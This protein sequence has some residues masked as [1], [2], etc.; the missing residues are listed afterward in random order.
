MARF[1]ID[2]PV[3]AWVIALFIMLGGAFAIRALPVAQYPDIAPPVVSIYAT[4]PGA[5]AQVV[6]ESVTALIEREMN[7][8]PGLLYTSATSSAGMASL[9]LTFR[10][11]VNA[12]LAAVEVQNRLKTVE[13]RLPEPVRR[14]G[15]QVEKAADNIQ[16]VVSLTSDDG[17]MTGV[18]LGEYASAN[19][20]QAL[21]R[22][23]GVG[24][25]QFWGAEYAMRIWPDPVKLAGHGLTASDIAAAVRA[26]N[27]RVTVGD[28]GRS[29]VPDSAPIAATVF[30]D[31]PLKTPAD[32]GAIALRSQADGAA[33]YLRDVAR[34]EFGGSD[35]NYPSY[36]NG[37]VAVGMGIK[38]AP[39]SNAVATEKR[40]RAA[41]DEL[42][43][44]FPPGVKYQIP[45]ETSSFVRVS[46]NKVVTT[47]IEAGVLV[48]LVMF[49]FMQNLRATLIPTLVVPVA[50][51]GTFG[52]MYAA[53]FSINVLTMFGM[54]L[55]IGILVDDAI[56]VVENVERLMVEERLAPYDATVKAMKQISGAIV[57]IT[58]VL[59]SVFVPMA[60]FGGAVGNIYR[61][62]AL[63]LAVSI[64]FSAFLAL[65]LTPALCATLLKP[66]DDGHH[67]KRGFFGWFN[68]FVARSTQR[69]ATRV[70]AMLNKPLRWL[71]VYGVLTAVAAL[72]LTRLPSAFLPDEDQGNFMVMVIRPQGTPLAETMQSVREVES[73]L[74]REEPAAYT[75]ALGGFNLYGE[76]PNGGMIFVTLKNW[77]ARQAARDHVQAIV[78]RVNERFAGTP[79]TT[80][81]AMNSPALPDLGSTGGFDFRMQNRGGLDYAAF[82]AAREQ[83]L[84][85]GAKDAALTDL[86]FAGTQD[87]PQLKLDIDRAK[88][89][90]LGVSMDE[91]NT[92]LA[93][94]FGS[95]Y[96]GDFMHGT[97]VRR[98]IVQAD[99][100]HRLDP[101]D[102][103]KLRVRNAR[104]EMVPLA[105]FATLQW[106]LGPPQLTRYNGYPSFTIN[107]SAAP[108]HSSGEA[109]AAIERIAATLPAGIGHAW[110]G[111]SFEE[112]LSGA[113]AP[114]LFALSV[115]VVFLALAALY[116]SWSI[117]LAVMLVV[118]LGVIG[119]VL[120]VT[121]RAMPN[122]IY[123]KVGLIATIG[124][125]AKNA[126]LI[127]E[128]AKDLL[129]QRMSLAEAAL[130]A[131]RLRLRPIVMT[132]L[133]FGVGVLPLAF[134]S[135]AASGAQTAI[136]T[137]VL[138]GVIAATVLAVFLVPLF[139]VVVGRLFGF[140]TRRRG[141]A[142]AVNVEGSR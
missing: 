111:Q 41:M 81:F 39:G 14:D 98:V 120:G 23:D 9:Y 74:R 17:R 50:L 85:A 89:S 33:L 108:G 44:Y 134:A 115:L 15:I 105:A 16:L 99:G 27:A 30:A 20:V 70:G 136:G 96:I 13:A 122:D 8:A 125:S 42:S 32:F 77:N 51:A 67:D 97:Q 124:L 22:V 76:G 29:A 138:G 47:L 116:E 11:G 126:I 106:T 26:H 141:S 12:D 129:A 58:V 63:S 35:Y 49:L 21:R 94:M 3:F 7:G 90:A 1:F 114:L 6:E 80:V 38:L 61:Q 84:A 59:T 95:D 130:E 103:K 139:F 68:R 60:F 65:S 55:A 100:Q 132:S 75:F 121:L 54:V 140:G 18:Q 118:P 25:V 37:K 112:R 127:V 62:F 119:A 109:M 104:G 135:G 78:A 137:G 46:M 133:A 87:A 79:N 36:V 110:S 57:G 2:R 10:Q 83:L 34:I 72:M 91:I 52:A 82:S 4:Y 131:A 24:R 56:V 92:T 88:A 69:Y 117:P 40:I 31:A 5:S 71:V 19:V 45:Y 102:V 113:Q 43:A 86:M 66:V 142:P 123:F 53:G 73:Y 128:V 64:A 107:G 48:F 28:I 101:D 93:V